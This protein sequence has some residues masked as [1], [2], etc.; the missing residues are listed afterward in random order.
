MPSPDIKPAADAF[1]LYDGE[2]AQTIG[3]Y[4][5]GGGCSIVQLHVTYDPEEAEAWR[6]SL[7]DRR[8]PA[9]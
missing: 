9:R 1:V 4:M 8:N 7:L 6:A 2:A 3:T 5:P